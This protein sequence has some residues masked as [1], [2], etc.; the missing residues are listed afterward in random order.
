[1]DRCLDSSTAAGGVELLT[2]QVSKTISE[3]KVLPR[4]DASFMNTKKATFE[5]HVHDDQPGDQGG[6]Q[7]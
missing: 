5:H 1:M 2:R 3:S 6:R 4:G 7:W